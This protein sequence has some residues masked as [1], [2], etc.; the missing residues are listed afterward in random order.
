MSKEQVLDFMEWVGD[1]YTKL[2]GVWVK[3]YQ[4]QSDSNFYKTSEEV[5]QDYFNFM[6][7]LTNLLNEKQNHK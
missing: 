1:N 4:N 7:N 3:K 5:Y 6:Q 2:H